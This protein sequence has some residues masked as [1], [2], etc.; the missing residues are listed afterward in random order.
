ML[1]D[2]MEMVNRDPVWPM[3]EAGYILQVVEHGPV[4]ANAEGHMTRLFFSHAAQVLTCA[5]AAAAVK[6]SLSESSGVVFLL[7]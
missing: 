3:Q 4:M 5:S 7:K 6:P 1:E 2:E